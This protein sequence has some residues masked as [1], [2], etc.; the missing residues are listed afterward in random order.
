[1]ARSFFSFRA[2]ETLMTPEQIAQIAHEVNRGYCLALG[3]TTHAAWA[4]TPEAERAGKLQGV[5][6][7]LEKPDSTPEQAHE[8]WLAKKAA[9]GWKFGETKNAKKKEHPC[10]KPYAELPAEQRAK[11]YIFRAVVLAAAAL[12]APEPIEKIVQVP[13]QVTIGQTPVKYIGHRAR[14]GDGLYGSGLFWHQGE[15]VMVPDEL[16]AK[17]LR[18]KE[19]WV[20][21]EEADAGVPQTARSVDQA[22]EEETDAVRVEVASMDKPA[23]AS[24]ALQRFQIELDQTREVELLRAEVTGLIDRFGLV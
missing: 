2:L 4:D 6:M 20:R 5:Q 24:F 19:V 22:A 21:G 14:Y 16:A 18:H 3:D 9:D 17:L 12:P 13:V 10:M 7:Y 1:M 11:D 8:S 15:T 23:L